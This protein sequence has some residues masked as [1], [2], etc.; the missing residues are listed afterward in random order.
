MAVNGP[1]EFCSFD[2]HMRGLSED[3]AGAILRRDFLTP[4]V[5]AGLFPN[6]LQRFLPIPIW[7]FDRARAFNSAVTKAYGDAIPTGQTT[8]RSLS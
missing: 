5:A 2:R 3:R 7:Q 6:F 1:T 8:S 4:L